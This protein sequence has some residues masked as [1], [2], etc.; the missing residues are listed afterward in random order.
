MEQKQVRAA[1][2]IL[3]FLH[4]RSGEKSDIKAYFTTLSCPKRWKQTIRPCLPLS[5]CH[6]RLLMF[7]RWREDRR[8]LSLYYYITGSAVTH[9]SA[10][11]L[12]SQLHRKRP[13]N[14]LEE[15]ARCY[16]ARA[17]GSLHLTQSSTYPFLVASVMYVTTRS[18]TDLMGGKRRQDNGRMFLHQKQSALCLY[19]EKTMSCQLL[20]VLDT[21]GR[22]LV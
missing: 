2:R 18:R 17:L 14:A 6:W 12:S 5:A 10:N 22:D 11:S 3:T 16:G 9:R 13:E 7:M 19:H 20:E 15:S 4:W 1:E 21:V 8:A